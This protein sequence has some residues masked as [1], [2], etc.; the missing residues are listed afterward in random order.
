LLQF[1]IYLLMVF[2]FE[3]GFIALVMLRRCCFMAHFCCPDT[4]LPF[5]CL[6]SFSI[7]GDFRKFKLSGLSASFT[8]VYYQG[9]QIGSFGAKNQTFGSC[10]KHLAPKFLFGYLWL[11]CNFFVPQIFFGK[12]LRVAHVACSGHHKT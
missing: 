10:E 5:Q 11:F 1:W 2:H 12:E 6:A 8:Q 9:C 4:F 3:N 7:M